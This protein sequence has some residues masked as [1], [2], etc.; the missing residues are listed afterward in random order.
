MRDSGTVCGTAGQYAETVCGNSMRDSGTVCGTRR[1]SM[2]KQSQSVT[3][4]VG[5]RDTEETKRNETKR[6]ETNKMEWMCRAA[7]RLID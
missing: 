1:D 7:G 3:Q 4:S 6:N 2:R 5:Q